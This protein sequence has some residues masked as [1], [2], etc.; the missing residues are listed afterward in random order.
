MGLLVAYCSTA[1]HLLFMM[2]YLVIILAALTRVI[3][4]M[5]NVAVVTAVAIFAGSVL[6]MRKALGITFLVRLFSDIV[7]GFFTW[8]LMVAVYAAHLLGVLFGRW[9]GSG[10]VS[11]ARF[12]K[13]VA[14]SLSTSVSFFV[15]TN[16]ALLYAEYPHTWAGITQAYINGLP[17]LRGTL[18]GDVGFSVSL[19]L[20]YDAARVLVPWLKRQRVAVTT[21]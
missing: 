12:G 11:V 7:I 1:Y 10:K 3:P 18:L 13:V 2:I 8:K 15:L 6:P 14:S 17:F 9:I 19:F 4:H 16:F 20:I 5:P 21:A